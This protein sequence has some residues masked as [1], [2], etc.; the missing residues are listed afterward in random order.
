[1]ELPT[2]HARTRLV[3]QVRN[4]IERAIIDHPKIEELTPTE[5]A[6]IL[7]ELAFRYSNVALKAEREGELR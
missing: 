2:L 1:M 4:E 3:N 5:L 6:T 7:A